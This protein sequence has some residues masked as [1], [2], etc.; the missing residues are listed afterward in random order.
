[1]KIKETF[2]V[3]KHGEFVKLHYCTDA[4]GVS[5]RYFIEYPNGVIKKLTGTEFFELLESGA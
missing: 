1:M 2:I 5:M 3:E 4:H